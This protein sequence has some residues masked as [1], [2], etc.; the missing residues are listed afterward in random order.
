MEWIVS[1]AAGVALAAA[2][3]FRVFVPLLVLSLAARAED[4]P[5][6]LA[7]EWQWVGSWWA[8]T[9]F[10]VA[11]VVEIAA[12]YIPWVDNALDAV[13]TPA[14]L[15]AGTFV[16]AASMGD[17][18]PMLRWTLA[19]IGG[20]GAAGA[21]Q[22]VTV[23][24]RAGSTATTGGLGN[25]LVATAEWLGSVVTAVLAVVIPLLVGML[26]VGVAGWFAVRWLRSRAR[27]AVPPP[28]DGVP[29][30]MPRTVSP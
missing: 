29:G 8:T 15:V 10:A 17:M 12:Y 19:A 4:S 21:V 28:A 26:V 7:A 2:T 20:G 18:D 24:V 22:G 5:V 11:T 23:L 16:A 13:A 27:P 25:P 3:G 14:A 30:T 1:V 9:A 6:R